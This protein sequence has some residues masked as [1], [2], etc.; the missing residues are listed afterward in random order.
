M[1]R[2][3]LPQTHDYIQGWTRFESTKVWTTR[4]I[5]VVKFLVLLVLFSSANMIILFHHLGDLV[6]LLCLKFGFQRR[7]WVSSCKA[8]QKHVIGWFSVEKKCPVLVLARKFRTTKNCRQSISTSVGMIPT[9]LFFFGS[10]CC[11]WRY[12]V[13]VED[14]GLGFQLLF[15]FFSNG[16]EFYSWSVSC[17]I[18]LYYYL[19]VFIWV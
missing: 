18:V 17:I 15:N 2:R 13:V 8:E 6:V 7:R 11:H 3:G 5:W 12:H 4:F 19:L 14:L 10:W 16:S 1:L 9:V